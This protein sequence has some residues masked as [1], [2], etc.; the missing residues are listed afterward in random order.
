[1]AIPSV[2][3]SYQGP[4]QSTQ[5]RNRLDSGRGQDAS[6]WGRRRELVGVERFTAHST[7]AGWWS[8]YGISLFTMPRYTSKLRTRQK[9]AL[10]TAMVSARLSQLW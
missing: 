6:C 8:L 7:N 3:I 9:I 4:L 2:C 10:Y 1:M 5:R